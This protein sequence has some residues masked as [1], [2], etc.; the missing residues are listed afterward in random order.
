[1]CS[2]GKILARPQETPSKYC[3][4]TEWGWRVGKGTLVV[5]GWCF[6]CYGKCY[7]NL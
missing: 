1:M 2:L 3:F 5:S 4:F 7:R 6:P